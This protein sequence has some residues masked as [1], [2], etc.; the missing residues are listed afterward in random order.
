MKTTVTTRRTNGADP[1]FIALVKELDSH[2]NT[3]FGAG[4]VCFDK[5]NIVN[6]SSTVLVAYVN[7]EPAGCG[8]IRAHDA[9]TMEI[10]R[11]FVKSRYRN[12]GVGAVILKE[13]E[14]WTLEMNCS[15]TVLETGKALEAAVSL[16]R[17]NGY[18]PIENYGPYRCVDSSVCMKKNV[19]PSFQGD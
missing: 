9:E 5:F 10:K 11:M 1:D 8:C 17:K 6:D 2:L 7:G 12:Q 4:Q 13:L 19:K 3:V 14:K 16:Y 15:Y 18:R